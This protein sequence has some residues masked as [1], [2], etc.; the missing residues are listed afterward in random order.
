MV[1]GEV[2]GTRFYEVEEENIKETEK[3]THRVYTRA[4]E[5]NLGN[6]VGEGMIA[7]F[8]NWADV[9]VEVYYDFFAFLYTWPKWLSEKGNLT[10]LRWDEFQT[11]L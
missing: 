1:Y 4:M 5:F 2:V 3:T 7:T 8:G 6:N 11:V 9:T 10:S